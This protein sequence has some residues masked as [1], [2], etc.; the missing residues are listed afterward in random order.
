MTP[1]IPL[2]LGGALPEQLGL[3]KPPDHIDVRAGLQF[4]PGNIERFATA[5]KTTTARGAIEA[6]TAALTATHQ[7]YGKMVAAADELALRRPEDRVPGR[8]PGEDMWVVPEAKKEEVRIALATAFNRETARIEKAASANSVAQSGLEQAIQNRLRNPRANETSQAH[9]AD[10]VR[11]HVKSLDVLSERANFF[12]DAITTGDLETV[13]SLLA[14]PAFVSGLDKAT[15]ARMRDLA[16][17]K[18]APDEHA[19]RETLRAVGAHMVNASN[20]FLGRTNEMM[21]KR[22]LAVAENARAL[23]ALKEGI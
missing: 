10:A 3:Q 9:I 22:N 11:A 1:N 16:E 12:H 13:T 19:D 18:F 4:H 5:I 20:L 23:K 17:K 8:K 6:A 15:M 14:A 21:P 7:T 2:V